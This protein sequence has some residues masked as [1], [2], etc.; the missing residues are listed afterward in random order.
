[1]EH[2]TATFLALKD[3]LKLGMFDHDCIQQKRARPVCLSA[4][5]S[6]STSIKEKEIEWLV[7]SGLRQEAAGGS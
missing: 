1:M 6:V 7:S 3:V 2:R 5:L 4:S